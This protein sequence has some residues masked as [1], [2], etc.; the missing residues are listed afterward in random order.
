M[1]V[2]FQRTTLKAHMWFSLAAAQSDDESAEIRDKIASGIPPNKRHQ[3][4]QR[5]GTTSGTIAMNL[6]VIRAMPA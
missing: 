4:V 3:A 6:K 1:A 2:V 5:L